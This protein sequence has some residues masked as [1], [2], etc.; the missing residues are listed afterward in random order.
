MGAGGQ[1]LDEARLLV[2][3]LVAVD[4][5]AQPVPLGHVDGDVDRAHAVLTGV[6]EVRDGADDVDPAAGGLLEQLLAAREGADAL[7]RE[8]DELQPDHVADALAHL[9]QRVEGDE[10]SG[11]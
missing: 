10:R 5:D 3:D 6:L 2:V 8:R 4:V 1:H 7:L 11:R 9:Q